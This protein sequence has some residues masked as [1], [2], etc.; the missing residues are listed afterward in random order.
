MAGEHGDGGCRKNLASLTKLIIADLYNL[1]IAII[2]TLFA[3]GWQNAF[4]NGTGNHEGSSVSGHLA[5][6]RSGERRRTTHAQISSRSGIDVSWLRCLLDFRLK[7]DEEERL[8]GC[9]S[10]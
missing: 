5:G 6:M 2:S 9:Q 4:Q 10:R 7:A 8:I 3:G 1:S